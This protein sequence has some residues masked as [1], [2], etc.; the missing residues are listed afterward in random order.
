MIDLHVMQLPPAVYDLT[1][2]LGDRVARILSLSTV[3]PT[4]NPPFA[5][6][7]NREHWFTKASITDLN[8]YFSGSVMKLTYVDALGQN[9]QTIANEL[10]DPSKYR[11]Q[12]YALGVPV[13]WTPGAPPYSTP[14]YYFEQGSAANAMRP[15][16]QVSGANPVVLSAVTWVTLDP[17]V[18]GYFGGAT[19]GTTISLSSKPLSSIPTGGWYCKTP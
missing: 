7:K 5:W 10:A 16:F 17:N 2:G 3:V 6:Q 15:L 18:T 1:T 13:S 4:T 12:F 11:F 9:L 19:P 14:A 8:S